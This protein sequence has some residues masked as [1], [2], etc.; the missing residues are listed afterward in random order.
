MRMPVLPR[1]RRSVRLAA[2]PLV[3]SASFAFG[4]WPMPAAAQAP[5]AEA[6]IGELGCAGC[7]AGMPAGRN[8]TQALGPAGARYDEA[9]LF[10]YLEPGSG[11]RPGSRARMP[12]FRL[13][14]AE[15][16]AL[17][18]FLSS[19]GTGA[20]RAPATAGQRSAHRAAG[21]AS[22]GANA[23]MGRKIFVALNCAGCHSYQGI[24][25]WGAGPDLSA[26]GSRVRPEWLTGYL[27]RPHAVRPQGVY[28]GTGS[29]MPDFGLTQPEIAVIAAYLSGR[30]VALPAFTPRPLAPFAVA[31]A[32]A[33]LR[34]ELSCLGCHRLGGDGGRIGPDLSTAGSRLQPAWIAAMVRDPQHAVPS[35]IMPR[36][37]MPPA[38]EQLITSYLAT[39]E[40]GA[41]PPAYPSLTQHAV[42]TP[43]HGDS[44]P[45]LYARSCSHCHGESGKGDGWNARYLPVRPTSHADKAYMSTRTDGTLFDAV[46]GGGRI[47]NRSNRMPPF[48]ETLTREQI[49]GLVD[50]MRS[51]C[52]CEGPDWSRRQDRARR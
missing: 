46:H 45:E 19:T 40:S 9:W 24:G 34:D 25:A 10:A 6:L 18:A 41:V 26:E 31:K 7:H 38:T 5:A 2:L 35:T 3:S 49:W 16:V 51:L 44:A 17:A 15:R 42:H 29:R 27:A 39:R 36:V 1:V 47:M 22:N 33:I 14:A 21:A 43:G 48:G 4:I 32:T 11:P 52:A 30:R 13:D 23:A 20:L 28:P 50:Y 8:G 12:D 37:P